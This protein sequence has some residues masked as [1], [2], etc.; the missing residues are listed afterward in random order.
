MIGKYLR[1]IWL[2]FWAGNAVTWI[3]VRTLWMTD[4]Y[5]L[6]LEILSLVTITVAFIIAIRSGFQIRVTAL[7]LCGLLVGQWWLFEMG[8][9]RAYW[10]IGGF[11]P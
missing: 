8:L 10:T 4:Q 6:I 11:A 5:Q 2:L 1:G 9:L 3:A 7:L